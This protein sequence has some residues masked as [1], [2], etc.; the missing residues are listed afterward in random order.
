M[1]D[2][3]KEFDDLVNKYRDKLL[4]NEYIPIPVYN[5]KEEVE[6]H[7]SQVKDEK[8]RGFILE[9]TNKL[10]ELMPKERSINFIPLFVLWEFTFIFQSIWTSCFTYYI[11]IR[12]ISDFL[13]EVVVGMVSII[14]YR[15]FLKS[16]DSMRCDLIFLLTDISFSV[17]LNMRKSCLLLYNYGRYLNDKFYCIAVLD[18]AIIRKIVDILYPI[19]MKFWIINTLIPCFYRFCKNFYKKLLDFILKYYWN[20]I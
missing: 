15:Y 14:N 6:I 20:E 3:Q 19:L 17:E 1:E 10:H 16:M 11:F 12:N 9:Y 13:Q 8:I 18:S 2:K 5:P 7:F 4:K